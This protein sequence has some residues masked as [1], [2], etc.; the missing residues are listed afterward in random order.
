MNSLLP[1]PTTTFG[2]QYSW[3]IVG[4]LALHAVVVTLIFGS[5]NFSLSSHKEFEVPDH[6]VASVVT[7]E[8]P[9]VAPKPVVKP[10]PTPAPKPVVK[11]TPKPVV[12]ETPKPV[13]KQ[14]PKPEPVVKEQPKP[15]QKPVTETVPEVKQPEV[16]E[17]E[18]EVKQPALESE[19][20]LF[21][22]LLEGLAAE[23]ASINEQIE[24]I[25]SN[26]AR[27]AQIKATVSSHASMI[28]A[29]IEQQWSRP[30][31][32]RLMSLQGI[33]AV[34][35]VELL[36]TGELLKASITRTSG[37]Q[38]FD[39]SVLRAVERVR[40]F[41]VP[42]NSEAFEQGGFRRLNITFRPEDLMNL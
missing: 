14:E 27:Q 40:R 17:P 24:I 6:I 31:E 15:V 32:L 9:K 20:D 29:Q 30:P 8:Q 19:E 33:E 1:A 2:K 12:K 23:E 26:Q 16:A 11:E 35:L 25:E 34:V 39:D 3:P 38:R 41:S 42:E 28:R 4:A 36:P 10:Q 7:I 13:V 18:P 22:N 37:N 5:W 21:S